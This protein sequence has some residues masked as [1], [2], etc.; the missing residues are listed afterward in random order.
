MTDDDLTPAD[1]VFTKRG[2]DPKIAS[3]RPYKRWT[4]DDVGPVLDAYEDIRP[5]QLRWMLGLARQSDG[6]VI[7]RHPPPGLDLG[8]VYAE[9]C[10]ANAVV[11]RT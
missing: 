9:L 6:L 2:I 3:D 4:T 5:G 7:T 10:P 11:T 8:H 1:D